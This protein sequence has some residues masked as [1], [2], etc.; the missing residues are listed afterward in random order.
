MMDYSVFG[1]EKLLLSV[2][3]LMFAGRTTDH[4]PILI[5]GSPGCGMSSFISKLCHHGGSLVNN[6]S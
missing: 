2:Q 1:F 5:T 4:Q 3:N 6:Q